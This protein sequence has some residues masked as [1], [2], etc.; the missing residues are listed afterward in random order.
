[1]SASPAALHFPHGRVLLARTRLAYVHLRNLLSDAKRD[2]S[3][4]ISGYVAISLPEELVTLYLLGGE[5]AN[6]TAWD[7][8]GSHA[9]AIA[10]AL[11]KIPAEPEYG[12]I[13]FNEAEK[14]LLSCMFESQSTPADPWPDE[15]SAK[16]PSVLFPYLMSTTFDGVLEI[17][18]N[19]H[20]SYLIFKNGTVARAYLSGGQ[21]G[22][23][24]ERVSKLFAR[25]GRVGDI[26]IS[27]RP[28]PR[29]LPVQA[30]PALIHAYRELSGNLVQRLLDLG[31]D[32]APA[33]AEHARQNLVATHP[34][35]DGF[36]FAGGQVKDP[37]ADS[38]AL[39]AGVAAWI[40]ELMWAASDHESVAP[41]ALLRELTWDRRHL[42]Q[43]AGLFSQVPWK[44]M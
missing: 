40:R 19:D 4:R 23:L 18:V 12:E 22:T 20:V 33:I 11:E 26:R 38:E 1:M 36:S 32:T 21:Q 2:R 41:D 24:V 29:K 3:A 10:T 7:A 39:T 44:V 13:C 14:E 9:I 5:V 27:R 6:A 42:F 43:S 17:I 8:R 25:E 31:R 15:M 35:L 34:S 37:L 30:S 28:L 16:D